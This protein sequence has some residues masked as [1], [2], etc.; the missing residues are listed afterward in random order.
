[1]PAE[2]TTAYAYS[3]EPQ[4]VKPG[5]KGKYRDENEIAPLSLMSDPR[6]VRGSTQALARKIIGT[7]TVNKATLRLK[8]T[9]A[10]ERATESSARP[11][12]IYDVPEFAGGELDIS[13]YLTDGVDPEARRQAMIAKLSQTD[14]FHPRPPSPKYVPRKTGKDTSTQMDVEDVRELF[15]FDREVAPMLDVIV[16]KTLEQ[17]LFEVQTEEELRRI[18]HEIGS[19]AATKNADAAWAAE[20]EEQTRKDEAAKSKKLEAARTRMEDTNRVK[21]TVAGL[22]MVRQIYPAIWSEIEADM[23]PLGSF[24]TQTVTADFGEELLK[25][26]A[27]KARLREAASGVLDEILAEAQG[28]YMDDVPDFVPATLPAC[29]ITVSVAK[30]PVEG[31][32]GAEPTTPPP[33]EVSATVGDADTVVSVEKSLQAALAEKAVSGVDIKLGAFLDAATRRK[34]ARDARLLNFALP[35]ALTL[36][37][38]L[39]D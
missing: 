4:A 14:A 34:I 17:A 22:Q 5:A 33:T 30:P 7:K 13:Q 6:V 20:S 1:M 3:S 9:Q 26:T 37:I 39:S 8:Q 38:S 31:E 27:D 25:C 15:D 35:E 16:Q 2:G 29:T 18:E 24:D 11:A 10:A 21:T 12:Y 23:F 28:K 19:Y 32:E 36:T